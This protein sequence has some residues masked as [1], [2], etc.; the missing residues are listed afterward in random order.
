MEAI[1]WV[2]CVC[3]VLGY[4]GMNKVWGGITFW[5]G[6]HAKKIQVY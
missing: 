5:L 6:L 2:V 4:E 3:L 1:V